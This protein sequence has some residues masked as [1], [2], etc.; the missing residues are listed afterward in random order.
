MIT[1]T[2][3][4]NQILRKIYKIPSDRLKELD[5]FVSKLEK[6]INKKA[7]TLSYAGS[8][9]DIDESVFEDFTENLIENRKKNR[10]RINE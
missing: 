1:D 8:W 7:K 5:D 10:K 3:R 4:R 9:K 2:Q 6:D